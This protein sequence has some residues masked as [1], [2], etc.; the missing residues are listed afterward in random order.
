MFDC[1]D[2]IDSGL[3]VAVK[4]GFPSPEILNGSFEYKG[5]GIA[6]NEDL[7][8]EDQECRNVDAGLKIKVPDGHVAVLHRAYPENGCE[9]EDERFYPSE[10][11]VDLRIDIGNFTCDDTIVH[12]K[13]RFAQLY[14]K[15]D[16]KKPV[17]ME[18]HP[19]KSV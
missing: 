4:E 16:A 9:V 14:L 11:V 5:Y 19:S 7:L 17:R 18:E 2:P 3:I 1:V 10:G 8:L 12:K 13:T 6:L 15:K